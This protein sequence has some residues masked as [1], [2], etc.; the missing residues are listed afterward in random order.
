MPRQASRLSA[1]ITTAGGAKRGYKKAAFEVLSQA[2][3]YH[4]DY[5]GVAPPPLPPYDV[6]ALEAEWV[7]PAEG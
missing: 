5:T 4:Q 2:W 7:E 6:A 3:A 1:T